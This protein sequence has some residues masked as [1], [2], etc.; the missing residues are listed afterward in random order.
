MKILAD[1]NIPRVTV[2]GFRAA[3]HDV[4]DIR[5]TSEEGLP[6]SDLWEIASK[7]CRLLITTDKGSPN[8][9]CHR[10]TEL[11]QCVCG[12]PTGTRFTMPYC[13]LWDAFVKASGRTCAGEVQIIQR[14]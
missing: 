10:T 13:K 3:G 2:E 11:W 12:N 4:K 8:I 1:E 7:E 9:G 14:G 6:D 5:G